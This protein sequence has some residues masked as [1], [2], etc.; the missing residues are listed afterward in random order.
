MNRRRKLVIALLLAA[1]VGL[2]A[3][4]VVNIIGLGPVPYIGSENATVVKY[5]YVPT[6]YYGTHEITADG[7]V[8]MAV[9][10][11][12]RVFATPKTGGVD[13]NSDFIIE[14]EDV[15][16]TWSA[17]SQSGVIIYKPRSWAFKAVLVDTPEYYVIRPEFFSIGDAVICGAGASLPTAY[18]VVDLQAVGKTPDLYVIRTSNTINCGGTVSRPTTKDATTAILT[19]TGPPTATFQGVM[20]QYGGTMRN[21]TMFFIQNMYI[22][23][24]TSSK[25]TTLYVYY[26]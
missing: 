15:Y 1:V 8:N 25:T 2:L 13:I 21:Q 7:T 5:A 26:K 14:L 19:A 23:A 20:Q 6:S 18:A 3:V 12:S 16:I 11:L 22:I 10:E 17:A 24:A 9:C 4:T